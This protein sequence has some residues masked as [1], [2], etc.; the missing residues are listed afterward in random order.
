MIYSH[1]PISAVSVMKRIDFRIIIV[2]F[3]AILL[4][5][6]CS[7]TNN[8]GSD[9]FVETPYKPAGSTSVP[10]FGPPIHSIQGESHISPMNNQA[11]N[12]VHGVVTAIRTDGLYI[13][14]LSPDQN[15]GTSEGIFVF[16]QSSPINNIGDEVLVS[17]KVSEYYPGGIATGNLSVTEIINP[18]IST[19]AEGLPLPAPVVI[20]RGGR[21]PPSQII[22]ENNNE[23]NP[24]MN[25]LDF[26]EAME[27]M[28]VQVDQAVVVGPTNDYHETVVLTDKGLDAGLRTPRGGILLRQDDYNPERII[29]DSQLTFLPNFNVGDT[30]DQPLVG[31]LDYSF[32]NFKLSLTQTPLSQS[33]HLEKETA[34]GPKSDELSIATFNV[35]NLDPG[36][37]KTRFEDYAKLIVNNLQSPDILSLDEVQDNNGSIDDLITDASQTYRMLINAIKGVGGPTYDYRDIPPEVNQDGGEPGGN[38]RVGFLFRTDRGIQ[39]IDHGQGGPSDATEVRKSTNGPELTLSP[40]RIDPQNLAFSTSR[41][42][43]AGEFLYK[44]QKIFIVGVHLP[45]KGGDSPVFGRFQPPVLSSEKQRIQQAEIIQT[46]IAKILDVDAQANLLVL[47]DFNDFQFSTSVHTLAGSNMKNLVLTLPENQQY[48]YV[49]EGNSQVLDQMLASPSLAKKMSFYN[50]IHVN[51]EFAVN[52]RL[53]DHDPILARFVINPG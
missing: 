42:P 11:V 30:F 41:K 19:I 3:F 49:Y 34:P 39:F 27:S 40:G 46:F 20:G 45:S 23:Y 12:N 51:A 53:S 37:G 5:T 7:V 36:D 26:Y 44:G 6:G 24:D 4:I 52:N 47:G 33:G 25:G 14:D 9:P 8:L 10:R 18:R 50:A 17:G 2:R 13:Q 1:H 29:I 22:K 31:V 48:S 38:I 43:L 28:L 32:G 35:Q 21:I 16:S 15:I